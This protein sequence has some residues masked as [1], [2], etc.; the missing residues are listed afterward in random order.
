RGQNQYHVVMEAAP[1]YW[2]SP[3][4]LNDLFVRSPQGPVVPLSAFAKWAS[5][6]APLSVNH[7][8]LFPAGTISFNL[9]PGVALGE[10]LAAPARTAREVQ[11][12]PT[13]H[14]M[15]AGTA[16]AYQESLANEAVLIATALATVY[17]V[18]GILYESTIHP[19]TILSTLPSAGVGAL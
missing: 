19:I 7:H 5:T 6:T 14:T 18:L 8:G 13:I 16:E 9:A 12:P 17:I 11:L 2:Q 4:T 3:T 15:F 1:Q 10:A